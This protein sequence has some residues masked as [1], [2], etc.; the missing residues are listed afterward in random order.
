MVQSEI[1]RDTKNI[2]LQEHK[3]QDPNG[4]KCEPSNELLCN[5]MPIHKK[6]WGMAN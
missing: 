6:F 3:K 5:I 1:S 4:T 2:I